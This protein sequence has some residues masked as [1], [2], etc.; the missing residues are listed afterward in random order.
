[1]FIEIIIF[2]LLYITF[3]KILKNFIFTYLNFCRV[4]LHFNNKNYL[5]KDNLILQKCGASLLGGSLQH[6]VF[7]ECSEHSK[8]LT[9]CKNIESTTLSMI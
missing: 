7:K 5:L 6:F 2:W 4:S 8:I 1:M 3:L 9:E